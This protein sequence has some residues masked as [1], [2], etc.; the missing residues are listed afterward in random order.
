MTARAIALGT[1]AVVLPLESA[2]EVSFSQH[3]EP[4]F[5]Q[6]C[7]ICHGEALQQSGLRLD[8]R[9]SAMLGGNS[10]TV[11]EPGDPAASALIKRLEGTGGLQQMP[12]GRQLSG[13]EIETIRRWIAEGAV[14]EDSVE[15]PEPATTAGHWG[16]RP[17]RRPAVPPVRDTDW[18]RNPI[19]A[20][21]LARLETEG[22]KP[23]AEA[24]A[25][26]L[27]RRASLDLTG[28]PPEPATLS[29]NLAYEEL[30][31][32]LL[33]SDH[34]GERW[35]TQWLDLVALRGLGRIRKG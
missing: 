5:K 20:F 29:R 22:L 9:D 15:P 11:V 8:R 25:H 13:T 6:H 1:F 10:G 26:T 21:V 2:G 3:V 35:A 17:I 30:V 12:P 24:T 31:E 34:F 19:D 4:I 28:L 7:V 16:F 27:A 33:Q 18:V 32:R 14:W 23:S